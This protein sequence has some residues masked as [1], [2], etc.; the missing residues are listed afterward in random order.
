VHSGVRLEV[1][2][3]RLYP[4][5]MQNEIKAPYVPVA[6]ANVAARTRCYSI[7]MLYR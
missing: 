5:G 3:L 4:Q 6:V 7:R 1:E 2:W